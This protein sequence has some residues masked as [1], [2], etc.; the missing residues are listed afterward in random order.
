M[1]YNRRAVIEGMNGGFKTRIGVRVKARR[2][3]AQSVE[4]PLRVVLRHV[5][6]IVYHRACGGFQSPPHREG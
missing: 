2:L 4:I 3:H 5:L 6:A 1:R